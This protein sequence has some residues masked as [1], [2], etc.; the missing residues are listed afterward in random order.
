[1][2]IEWIKTSFQ[3]QYRMGVVIRSIFIEPDLFHLV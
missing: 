3:K 2:V 1:M